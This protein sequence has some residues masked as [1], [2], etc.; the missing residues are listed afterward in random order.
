VWSC[1]PGQAEL[2]L[3]VCDEITSALDVSVQA[4][5]VQ[6]PGRLQAERHLAMIFVTHNLALMRA[7]AQ[8]VVVLS[9][10]AVAGAG[11][12]S[13]P[14]QTAAEPVMSERTDEWWDNRPL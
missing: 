6:L 8:S 4:T 14:A 11:T 5:I 12:S 10:G 9:R 2:D 7:I 1:R 3:L 13:R